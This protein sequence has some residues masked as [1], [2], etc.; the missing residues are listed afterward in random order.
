MITVKIIAAA[1][2][3]FTFKGVKYSVSYYVAGV[4][5]KKPA[6]IELSNKLELNNKLELVELIDA[7]NDQVCQVI[8][9][10]DID[11]ADYY[12]TIYNGYLE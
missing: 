7:I 10:T 3:K 4:C 12:L 5:G 8:V 9:A 11:D 1:D 6:V 2:T